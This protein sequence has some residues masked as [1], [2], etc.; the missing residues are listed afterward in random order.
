MK[1]HKIKSS[2]LRGLSIT[3]V[4]ALV[5]TG[6]LFHTGTGTLS[7]FGWRGIAAICP[8]GTLESV[9]ATRTLLPRVAVVFVLFVIVTVV[10]GRVFCAWLCPIPPIRHFFHPDKKSEQT[11]KADA[12]HH[13]DDSTIDGTAIDSPDSEACAVDCSTRGE[14]TTAAAD[15]S[16]ALSLKSS[17]AENR[18]GLCIDS[19]HW[20]LG[21]ALLS[22]AVFGFPVF[23]LV[24]PIGLTFATCIGIWRL[25]QFNE[26]TWSLVV[27]PVILILELVV[28]RTW[29]SRI[30]PVGALLSLFSV[31]NRF[32]RPTVDEEKCLRSKGIPCTVC[33]DVCEER[34]DPHSTSI[35][36]CTKC[37]ECVDHC[38][39]GAVS[40]PFM[41]K[42][43]SY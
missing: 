22:T 12:E 19:R 5:A 38:P 34:L 6:L 8:L 39:A 40:I 26:P 20:V 29:C 33:T 2:T 32:F 9:L 28:F 4:F 17:C 10:F 1:R 25:F 41:S 3:A 23:C 7:S 18:N 15:E 36:E 42:K 21:G 43:K 13:C 24:C 11:K 14:T 30:C 31:G 27:F 35:P 16:L 37:R